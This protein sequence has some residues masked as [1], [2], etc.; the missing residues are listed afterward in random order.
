MPLHTTADHLAE[1]P[2]LAATVGYWIFNSVG[3]AAIDEVA[4]P[5]EVRWLHLVI[6]TSS[7]PV[8]DYEVIAGP[9]NG[10]NIPSVTSTARDS[11]G[12]PIRWELDRRRL[13][14]R[15]VL[16]VPGIGV[17]SLVMRGLVLQRLADMG[18]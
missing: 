9:L 11:L 3:R 7:G 2:W 12:N 5:G 17:S 16:M 8:D 10:E 18:A 4:W 6:E 1:S 15:Q 14:E 13:G